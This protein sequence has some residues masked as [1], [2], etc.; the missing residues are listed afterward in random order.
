MPQLFPDMIPAKLTDSSVDSPP[1][2]LVNAMKLR[3][4]WEYAADGPIKGKALDIAPV[5]NLGGS[6]GE[7]TETNPTPSPTP[8]PTP[9][10][11]PPPPDTIDQYKG[12]IDKE[13]Y[14]EKDEMDQPT[15]TKIKLANGKEHIIGCGDDKKSIP[16]QDNNEARPDFFPTK[17]SVHVEG[18][19]SPNGSPNQIMPG[20]GTN[21]S[22]T[23]DAT[24]YGQV[25]AGFFKEE[26]GCESDELFNSYNNVDPD[27]QQEKVRQTAARRNDR[28]HDCVGLVN[29]VRIQYKELR[30]KGATRRRQMCGK[31]ALPFVQMEKKPNMG[32]HRRLLSTISRQ[33]SSTSGYDSVEP[34]DLQ[35]RNGTN[36]SYNRTIQPLINPVTG[37]V[38]AE[39]NLTFIPPGDLPKIELKHFDNSMYEINT[40]IRDLKEM[41]PQLNII[42]ADLIRDQ[43]PQF[44]PEVKKAERIGTEPE[45]E[46]EDDGKPGTDE[47]G[48]Q[49]TG[50]SAL[51]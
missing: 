36:S 24:A 19:P 21:P 35:T 10:P 41:M 15:R 14:L 44:C 38:I 39:R 1:D 34:V 43:L 46:P 23:L 4:G 32:P 48:K 30:V 22:A 25:H 11:G 29:L 18:N 12:D 50:D 9:P 8:G 28:E 20:W 17:S 33:P 7:S 3:G 40:C 26:K 51:E 31:N 47:D 42:R 2:F 45:P 5:G 37:E 16:C 13:L 49:P 27:I 6:L